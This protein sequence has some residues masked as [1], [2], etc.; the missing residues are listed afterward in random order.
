MISCAAIG[1]LL[2]SG[3][4]LSRSSMYCG[5]PNTFIVVEYFV[6]LHIC[7]APA[8]IFWGIEAVM[9]STVISSPFGDS[10]FL[11]VFSLDEASAAWC[12]IPVRWAKSISN[13]D[14]C[15]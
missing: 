8:S 13:S 10:S 9:Q 12:F 1:R 14:K 6:V 4:R 7:I 3:V 5:Y 11:V 2:C 15:S